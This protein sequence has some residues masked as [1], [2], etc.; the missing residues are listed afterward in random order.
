MTN[1][2]S[3]AV[4]ID[5]QVYELFLNQ[6]MSVIDIIAASSIICLVLKIYYHIRL[7]TK[8]KILS[9]IKIFGQNFGSGVCFPILRKSRNSFEK[10]MIQRANFFYALFLLLFTVSMILILVL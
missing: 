4:V 2:T 10:K 1:P 6:E 3:K 9:V 5:L 8:S 7:D